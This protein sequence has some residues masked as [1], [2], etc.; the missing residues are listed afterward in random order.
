MFNKSKQNHK[1]AITLR[2]AEVEP[3]NESLYVQAS[4]PSGSHSF[5][6]QELNPTQAESMTS[7]L[8]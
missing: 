2:V 7:I 6:Q 8:F 3:I 4:A 1:D 5:L